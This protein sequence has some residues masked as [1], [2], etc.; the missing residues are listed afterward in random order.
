M[1]YKNIQAKNT[2]TIQV[3]GSVV[4]GSRVTAKQAGNMR[5]ILT[6]IEEGE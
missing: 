6:G 3:Q 4:H 2:V 1:G 5:P